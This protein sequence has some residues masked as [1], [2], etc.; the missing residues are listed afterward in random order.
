[1]KHNRSDPHHNCHHVHI[2]QGSSGRIRSAFF[3]NFLFT[4]IEFVGGYFTNSL[5]I[6]S[7]AIH[8]L[9]DSLSLGLAWA[10]E[11]YSLKTANVDNTYGY[12]RWSILSALISSILIMT[13][14]LIVMAHSFERLVSPEPVVSSGVMG[15]A[16]LGVTFNLFAYWKLSGGS[17]LNEKV[18]KYHLLEDVLGWAVVL[19]GGV[20]IYFTNWNWLDPLLATATAIWIF[21]H[22]WTHFKSSL[23]VFMQMWPEGLSLEEV[24]SFILSFEGVRGVHHLHGWSIDGE[25]HI[26]TMHVVLSPNF[27]Q[28]AWPFLKTQIKAALKEKWNIIEVTLESEVE[29]EL[30]ADPTHHH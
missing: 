27:D 13:G 25:H 22:V 19:V 18:L 12:R 8:D 29:N 2:C 3:I 23:K 5:A 9:G 16:I 20:V 11:K 15:L 17:S 10:L 4:F 21:R 24:Q 14:S 30:C 26:V 1:V 6:M 7:D 28:K